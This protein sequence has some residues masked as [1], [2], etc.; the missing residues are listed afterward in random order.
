MIKVINEDRL[1]KLIHNFF[2]N[3]QT[4]ITELVQNAVRA[5]AQNITIDTTKG[6]LVVTDDGNGCDSIAPLLTL[7]ESDWDKEI[8]ENQ[9]PA[10]WGLFVLYCLA[11]EVE[12]TSKF[13]TLRF[14]AELFLK[15]A[16]YRD[17]I[18]D[19][20]VNKNKTSAG[21]MMSAVLKDAIQGYFDL[22]GKCITGVDK[23]TLRFFPIN[24]KING[25]A[26]QRETADKACKDYTIKT[27]YMGNK[28]FI[29]VSLLPPL[30]DFLES[31]DYISVLWYGAPIHQRNSHIL[32]E[33]EQGCPLT[34]VLP[35][36][37]AIKKDERFFAFTSFIR[38]TIVD[39]C[40]KRINAPEKSGAPPTTDVLYQAHLMRIMSTIA[41]RDELNQLNSFFIE[42]TQPYNDCQNT[43]NTAITRMVRKGEPV[44]SDEIEIALVGNGK[45]RALAPRRFNGKKHVGDYE[46][47]FLPQDAVIKCET[48]KN[49]PEWLQITKRTLK[50]DIQNQKKD[51]YQGK[52]CWCKSKILS[53]YTPPPDTAVT[54]GTGCDAPGEIDVIGIDCYGD[55]ESITIYHT[56]KPEAVFRLQ[57]TISDHYYNEDGDT[58][59]TQY[60]YIAEIIEEDLRNVCGKHTVND[61]LEGFRKVNGIDINNIKTI[62]VREKEVTITMESGKKKILSLA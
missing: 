24:I 43:R 15:D 22:S 14:D 31:D 28:V 51:T 44:F 34:P 58:Y 29:N 6:K 47:V 39:Y 53:S 49:R 33:V 55:Q 2:E 7:A 41:T 35:F 5:K 52:M 50:V 54:Y 59:E 11:R 61:L 60:H 23:K 21:F 62:S 37:T 19:G 42:E 45:R 25:E 57:D 40:A 3:P 38:Q 36:R 10:G 13:G 32:I 8:E 26:V 1:L 48:T 17:S 20:F 12:I 4:L 16:A 9:Q 56:G 46:A 18:T 30:F 27:R